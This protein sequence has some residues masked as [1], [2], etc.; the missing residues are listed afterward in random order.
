LDSKPWA[1]L[2]AQFG[3][4]GLYAAQA[5]FAEDFEGMIGGY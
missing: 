4:I 2:A 1:R 3:H 5:F